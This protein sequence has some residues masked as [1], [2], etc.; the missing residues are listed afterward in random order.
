[1]N[2]S[3]YIRFVE[4]YLVAGQ[5]GGEGSVSTAKLIAS[6]TR[7]KGGEEELT[8]G[9]GG[10]IISQLLSGESVLS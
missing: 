9:R 1:V 4:G 6:S 10:G 7:K 8:E 5:I 2:W 3:G